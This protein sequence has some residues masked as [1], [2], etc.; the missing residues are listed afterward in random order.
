M[1]VIFLTY[2]DVWAPTNFS[3]QI[4]KTKCDEYQDS[5]L[6]VG[7]LLILM[8]ILYKGQYTNV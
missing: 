7:I 2:F 8:P 3:Y 1:H 5:L 6:S 4:S